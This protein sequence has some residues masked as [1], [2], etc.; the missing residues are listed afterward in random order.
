M[1]D[2]LHLFAV[3]PEKNYGETERDRMHALATSPAVIEAILNVFRA[4]HGE[5]IAFH[6]ECWDIWHSY[7]LGSYIN[8]SLHHIQRL[9]LFEEK[10]VY[11]GAESP[12]ATPK[13]TPKRGKQQPLEKPYLGYTCLYRL[14]ETDHQHGPL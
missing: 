5:F 9:G 14:K 2:Q 7:G 10:R 12:C 8:D 3:P 4:H 1:T 13:T 11:H 6:Q